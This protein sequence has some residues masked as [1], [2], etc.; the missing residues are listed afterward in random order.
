MILNLN[1]VT[2]IWLLVFYFVFI[3]FY[4]FQRYF[5]E[6]RVSLSYRP[7][8]THVRGN[9]QSGFATLSRGIAISVMIK[10]TYIHMDSNCWLCAPHV[11]W[12]VDIK[13]PHQRKL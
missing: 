9:C 11:N 4:F 12:T 8:E 3:L 13:L 6:G 1:D 10:C 2:I 7:G 5:G